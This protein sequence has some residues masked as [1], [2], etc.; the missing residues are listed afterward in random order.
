MLEL[1]T[2]EVTLTDGSSVHLRLTTK[3]I[4]KHKLKYGK[5]SPPL[6]SLL[7]ALEDYEARVDLLDA[8]LK[9]PGNNNAIKDG[10]DLLDAL[11]DAGYSPADIDRLIIDLC[12][13]CGLIGMTDLG[14]YQE[15]ARANSDRITEKLL[16]LLTGTPVSEL[17]ETG[18]AAP[19][20]EAE[21]NPTRTP[22]T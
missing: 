15:A 22:R 21:E 10:S 14:K 3:A 19:A 16:G 7:L 17:V 5:D 12:G 4:G 20:G 18:D 1:S 13:D 6:L 8:A 2:R 11:T 9:Y